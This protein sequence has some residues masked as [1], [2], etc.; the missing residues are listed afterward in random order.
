MLNTQ[1]VRNRS[2][3]LSSINPPCRFTPHVKIF[4]RFSSNVMLHMRSPR[5]MRSCIR[6]ASTMRFGVATLWTETCPCERTCEKGSAMRQPLAHIY[7]TVRP[8]YGSHSAR[9][10]PSSWTTR[11]TVSQKSSPIATI[12]MTD[13]SGGN[14]RGVPFWTHL[15]ILFVGPRTSI[16]LLPLI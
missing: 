3:G 13:L 16:I 7:P 1:L 15:Q 5:L 12:S 9:R 6:N 11:P 4:A 8:R 10:T 2:R 14:R